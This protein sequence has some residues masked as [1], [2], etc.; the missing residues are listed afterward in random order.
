MG[1]FSLT[2][3][4]AISAII[5]LLLAFHPWA[6]SQE[7][8]VQPGIRTY[9]TVGTTDLKAHIFAPANASKAPRP[10]IILLHGGGWNAG[11][12]EWTYDDARRYASMGL[13]AIAGEYRLSDQK[14]ITP[15]E[16]MADT[17]DLIRWIRQ[18]AA[19]LNVDPHRIAVYGISA[20]GHLAASAAVFPHEDESKISAVP[21][22]LLLLSPAVSIVNDHWPQI[23]LGQRAEVKEIS[24]AENIRKQLPPIIII[25]GA[26]DTE[27]PLMAAQRFCDLAKQAGGTCDLHIYPGVGH[28]LS[29]NLDPHA[30]EQGPFDPDPAARADAHAQED[31]FLVRLGYAK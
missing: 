28:I 24:P 12:P 5:L 21:D 29:R 2:S 30:Q 9:K 18:N 19:D 7:H 1:D 6:A 16:A 10:A 31:A 25:E 4:H 23:L 20:G 26:A 27:T 14:T 22:A 11:S 17:R 8:A 13:V 15:L 3:P